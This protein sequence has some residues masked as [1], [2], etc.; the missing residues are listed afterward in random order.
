MAVV[1]SMMGAETRLL[2]GLRRGK[3]SGSRRVLKFCRKLL[4]LA[5]LRGIAL[6][7]GSVGLILKLRGQSRR[8]LFEECGILLLNL[9]E[10]AQETGCRGNALRIRCRLRLA[11][12]EWVGR[13]AIDRVARL[14]SYGEQTGES[15]NDHDRR[16][17]RSQP[18]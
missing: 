17:A 11:G 8:D 9:L 3:L 12:G 1:A 10:H 16:D 2:E 5:R 14:Q 4:E 6:G 18:Q 13:C 7:G 15:V